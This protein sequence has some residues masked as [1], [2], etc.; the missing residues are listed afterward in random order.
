[1]NQI[2]QG[3]AHKGIVGLLAMASML[4]ISCGDGSAPAKLDL[5]KLS[6]TPLYALFGI[7]ESVSP[8]WADGSTE[9][10]AT[11]TMAP[12]AG[13]SLPVGI[14]IDENKGIVSVSAAAAKQDAADY[15][16]SLTGTGDYTG[17]ATVTISIAVISLSAAELDRGTDEYRGHYGSFSMDSGHESLVGDYRL[18]LRA[19]AAAE[20]R[21]RGY[22]G[23][24]ASI[25][26]TLS[27]TS[28]NVFMSFHMDTD[29]FDAA[30]DWTQSPIVEAAM[31]LAMPA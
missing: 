10:T 31:L 12:A 21:C 7:G 27:T 30:A 19:A 6:Y 29:L 15:T 25:V 9:P 22:R 24:S 11:F 14:D 17:T 26:R 4:L 13:G 2:F 20:P 8:Q 3:Y 5:P 16:V 1:M 23:A 18:A 28:I